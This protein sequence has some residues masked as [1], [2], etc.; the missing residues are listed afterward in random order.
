MRFFEG[1]TQ[2]E[3]ATR[4]GI[5]QMHVSRLLARSLEQ[6]REA[7]RSRSER[8]CGSCCWST[9]R[10]RRS[11]RGRGSSSRR[12]WPPTTTS[13][14]PRPAGAATPPGWP[15]AQQPRAPT[16]SSCS[17]ATA[18]STR[19][20]TAWPGAR[21]RSA[22]CPV[23]P[24]TCSPAPSAWP[25]TRSRPPASCWR[26]GARDRAAGSG[27]GSANGRYFLFHV[28]VGFDAAVVEQVEKRGALKRYAGHPLFV[29]A[30][31]VTW[32]RHYDRSRPRFAVRYADGSLIDDGYF[33]ICLKTNPYTYL[34]NRPFRVGARGDARQPA[35]DGDVPLAAL[36]DAS[37][38]GGRRRWR[39]AGAC[40]A[41]RMID[42]RDDVDDGDRHRPRAV[43]VPGRRRLPRRGRAA[44][45][46]YEPDCLE[47]ITGR[48]QRRLTRETSGRW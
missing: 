17:A 27:W 15:R 29:W 6:L 16:W 5:S 44:R 46:R 19:R 39:R 10:P 41:T 8:S 25:T 11:R 23:G 42:Q 30:A 34:G 36:R 18:R 26:L 33:G 45:L 13:R 40:A 20:P 22:C 3:I 9:R 37:R 43:P 4:L 32:I 2:S 35:R 28:G 31:V 12:R 38:C 14:W 48:C 21:R 47:L 7:R 1:L 24:P